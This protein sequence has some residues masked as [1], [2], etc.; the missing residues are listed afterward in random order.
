MKRTCKYR[1]NHKRKNKSR[2]GT[3][4]PTTLLESKDRLYK[5]E[6]RQITILKN[7]IDSGKSPSPLS[8]GMR[9][10]QNSLEE[11]QYIKDMESLVKN[12]PLTDPT[13]ANANR[14][15]TEYYQKKIRHQLTQLPKRQMTQRENSPQQRESMRKMQARINRLKTKTGGKYSLKRRKRKL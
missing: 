10:S 13:V 2:G 4:R 3:Y 6:K 14:I 15:I 11:E 1:K 9:Y 5:K 7:M 8:Y 12:L